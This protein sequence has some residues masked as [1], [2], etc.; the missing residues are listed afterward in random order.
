MD[1]IRF[2][3][4]KI[5]AMIYGLN[6]LTLTN[7]RYKKVGPPFYRVGRRVFYR[8]AD[9]EAWFASHRVLTDSV[10]IPTG[11][12]Q[13]QTIGGHPMTVTTQTASLGASDPG[14]YPL[15][16]TDIGAD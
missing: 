12:E 6:Q 8:V 16:S 4:P 10:A 14:Y 1:E 15:P 3:S 5:A 9:F 2:I 7:Y 13:A 11:P